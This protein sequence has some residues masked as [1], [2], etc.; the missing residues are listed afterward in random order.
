MFESLKREIVKELSNEVM[1][2]K[3]SSDDE[4][5]DLVGK[6]IERKMKK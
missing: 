3:P 2:K 6:V 4:L 5:K 1:E